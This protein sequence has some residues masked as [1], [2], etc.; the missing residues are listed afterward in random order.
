MLAQLAAISGAIFSPTLC[1]SGRIADSVP[2]VGCPEARGGRFGTAAPPKLGLEADAR[3]GR[4]VRQNRFAARASTSD[5]SED[6]LPDH[7][8]DQ[9][10][11]MGRSAVLPQVQRLPGAEREPAS[12]DR[13]RLR[14]FRDRGA[15]VGRHIIWALVVV[16]PGA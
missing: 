14:R 16:L 12:A 15:R 11:R 5:E 1:R 8:Y 6:L 9:A 2:F 7:V 13:N 3:L 4:G 10:T